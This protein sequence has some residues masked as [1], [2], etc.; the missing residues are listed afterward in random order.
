MT[1]FEGEPH[2]KEGQE[3]AWVPVQQL[4]EFTFPEANVPIVAALIAA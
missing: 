1:D 4:G 3:V 2:G